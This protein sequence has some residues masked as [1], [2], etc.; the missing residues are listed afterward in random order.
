MRTRAVSRAIGIRAIAVI[1]PLAE[2]AAIEGVGG[3]SCG[4]PPAEPKSQPVLTRAA[5][6]T[7]RRSHRRFQLQVLFEGVKDVMAQKLDMKVDA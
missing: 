1:S 6:E 3:L 5:H 7:G 4:Q 2:G